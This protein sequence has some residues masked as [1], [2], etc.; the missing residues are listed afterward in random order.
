MNLQPQ[1]K[2]SNKRTGKRISFFNEQ[3]LAVPG[4]LAQVKEQQFYGTAVRPPVSRTSDFSKLDGLAS[5]PSSNM[6]NTVMYTQERPDAMRLNQQQVPCNWNVSER[7]DPTWQ[8]QPANMWPRNP[9]G[10]GITMVS[11]Y[12]NHHEP[13]KRSQD[14]AVGVSQL[15]MYGDALQQMMS[16]KA[17]L[18]HH[19]LAQQQAHLNSVLQ[20]QQQQQIQQQQIQQQQIQ[21]QQI[22]QQQIQQQQT[23][24]LSLQPF[25]MAFGH[26]GQKPALSELFHVFPNA[27]SNASFASQQ[28]PQP[29]L[30]QMQ[31]FENFYPTQQQQQATYG[32]Q[33]AV[34]MAQP[35]GVAQQKMHVISQSQLAPVSQAYTKAVAEH[36]Q[37]TVLPKAQIPLPRRS[38]RLSKEGLPPLAP[39]GITQPFEGQV[40]NQY[41]QN[42]YEHTIP[43]QVAAHEPYKR[44]NQ[45]IITQDKNYGR[46]PELDKAP[47]PQNGRAGEMQPQAE[48]SG[49]ENDPLAGGTGGVIQTTRRRRRISQEVNLFTL[50]QKASELPSLQNTKLDAEASGDKKQSLESKANLDF[51]G[52]PTNKRTRGDGDLRPLVMPVSVP[53]KMEPGKEKGE[54]AT[55]ERTAGSERDSSSSMPS[56]I[57]T[58]NRAGQANLTEASALKNEASP[59]SEGETQSRKPKRPRPEPLFIPPKSGTFIVPVLYSNITP[60]QSH[61]RSPVR[62]SDHPCD[63]NF[64]LPPYTPPPILS[65][66]REG[67]GLYFNAILS[68]STHGMPPPITPKSS[69]RTLLRSNSLEDMPP[70]LTA[71]GEATPVS[72]EPRINIGP[73]FQAN[74][75]DLRDLSSAPCRE[76]KANLVWQPWNESDNS[77]RKEVEELLTAACSSILP[78]GGT[79]QEL[80]LHY[81]HETKGN[82][83]AALAKLLL[84]KPSRIRNHPLC[85]YHYSGSDR[86]S[87]EEKRLFNKGMAIYK[88]DFLLVQKLIKTKTVA[89]CVEFYYTYKKQVKIGRNG[90]LIFGDAEPAADDKNPRED[91]EINIKNSHRMPPV[92]PPRREIL[93]ERRAEEL[94]NKGFEESKIQ[95]H[96]N[97]LKKEEEERVSPPTKVT[98]TLEASEIINDTLILRNQESNRRMADQS[99][100]TR[101][102]RPRN[103]FSPEGTKPPVQNKPPEQEGIFPCKKCGRVFL[104]V[105]SRSA[106]MKSHAEQEK[107]A[108]AQRQNEAAAQR[109][110]EAAAQRQNEAAAQRQNEAAAQRQNEAAAQRQNGAAAQRQ[111]GAA[112]QR[113][114]GAAAQRQNGAAAAQAALQARIRYKESSDSESSDSSSSESCDSSYDGEI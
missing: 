99:S 82:V 48:Q 14:K 85:D 63:R 41:M 98:Q 15:D 54:D 86:W 40:T 24:H 11:S 83:L 113:Q 94:T 58:R 74:I 6:L 21:Q 34:T 75:P 69:T 101:E 27:P 4:K 9:G 71:M 56:V 31:L 81:L 53:V 8:A 105:K 96:S 2:A 13:Q 103:K 35:H 80:T 78:G 102:R 10:Y 5:A 62:V 76:H 37:Q 110:N 39:T 46:L 112:A 114:N 38:R 23:Q 73:R 55:M 20:A 52:V 60:Y 16:Q 28:K 26:Q 51:A 59:I 107:K 68:A 30:P 91:S 92:I 36:N 88:K 93:I 19:T 109:Q 29:A 3:A 89:Q 104:K 66:V 79:N 57:V 32:V 7:S 45:Q 70:L 97:E 67:S 64:E 33:P 1:Q 77:H 95:V 106:H 50:A 44:G 72:I 111:N 84:K 87:V 49:S 25:Q 18:E 47:L 90:I 61:L 43:H 22:Q 108:A 17:Q 42:P 100:R 12:H 65:P